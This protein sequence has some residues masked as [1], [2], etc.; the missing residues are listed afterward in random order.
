MRKLRNIAIIAHVDHGKTTLVDK[1]IMQGNLLRDN[2]HTGGDLIMDNN[3][4]ERERG[5]TILSKNVSV[6]YQDYKI[7]ISDLHVT[8][9]G[10]HFTCEIEAMLFDMT[11][12]G[13]MCMQLRNIGSVNTVNVTKIDN[14]LLNTEECSCEAITN[15]E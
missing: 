5:I 12:L 11:M 3:D 6:I 15:N 13:K 1:M 8:S 4:I 14:R 2:E 9:D 10:D 7:N